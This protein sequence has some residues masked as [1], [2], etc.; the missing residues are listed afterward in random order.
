MT[1]PAWSGRRPP[2][3]DGY[4]IDIGLKVVEILQLDI[5]PRKFMRSPPP[6]TLCRSYNLMVKTLPERRRSRAG[7]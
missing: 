6:T 5:E 1:T 4:A 3:R 7:R 2:S